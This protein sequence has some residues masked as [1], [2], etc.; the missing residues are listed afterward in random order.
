[1]FSLYQN[2][3]SIIHGQDIEVSTYTLMSFTMT[4]I[5]IPWSG[6]LRMCFK[7]VVLP[8]PYNERLTLDQV[9]YELMI[10]TKKPESR[11]TGSWR[12]LGVSC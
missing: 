1:M 6:D 4:A 3:V 10:P 2:G 8:L 12:V 11:V 9:L 5:R 7:S